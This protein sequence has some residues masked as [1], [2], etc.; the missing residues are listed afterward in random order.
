MC[1]KR[2][3]IIEAA[4]DYFG[5][6][7][8][9][10]RRIYR[11]YQQW[12]IADKYDRNYWPLCKEGRFDPNRAFYGNVYGFSDGVVTGKLL[13]S[14]MGKEVY[15]GDQGVYEGHLCFDHAGTGLTNA[16][17]IQYKDL[18]FYSLTY[19]QGANGGDITEIFTN[20]ILHFNGWEIIFER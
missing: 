11:T 19:D 7:V 16:G 5:R 17:D 18:M 14:M 12:L 9:D 4:E 3:E 13:M 20:V 10:V 2:Q 6:K 8:Q 15:T 1:D